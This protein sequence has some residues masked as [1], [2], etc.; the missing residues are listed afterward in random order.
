MQQIDGRLQSPVFPE[1][2]KDPVVKGNQEPD[3]YGCI[4][5]YLHIICPCF[6]VLKKEHIQGRE[7]RCEF[8]F[9]PFMDKTG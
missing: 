3:Q 1:M 7:L 2:Y 6:Y 5:S 4:A 9:P 8:D